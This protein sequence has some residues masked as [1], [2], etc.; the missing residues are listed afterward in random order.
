MTRETKS[1]MLFDIIFWFEVLDRDVLER[2]ILRRNHQKTELK[3][4]CVEADI[5][6]LKDAV[7]IYRAATYP[8]KAGDFDADLCSNIDML[9][10]YLDEYERLSKTPPSGY[11]EV[12][13]RRM[14][15]TVGQEVNNLIMPIKTMISKFKKE[16]RR[17]I[18]WSRFGKAQPK[19]K[20]KSKMRQISINCPSE[21][22]VE[23]LTLT[24]ESRDQFVYKIGKLDDLP[25]L[26][27]VEKNVND[28]RKAFNH[29]P[30]VKKQLLQMIATV[31]TRKAQLS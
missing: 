23:G 31:N 3:E 16:E 17:T 30:A 27:Q 22:L 18:K 21:A 4:K 14:K 28:M 5:I 24:K 25:G 9:L 11:S 1:K 12:Q 7:E 20:E 26:I 2:R 10:R 15:M 8:E 6:H 13:L 19:E 29:S